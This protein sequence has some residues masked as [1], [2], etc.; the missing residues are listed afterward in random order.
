LMQQGSAD[1]KKKW[2]TRP[3]VDNWRRASSITFAA[4]G[5]GGARSGAD[6]EETAT[7][8]DFGLP[9]EE[10]LLAKIPNTSQQKEAAVKL[11]QKAYMQMAKAYFN[12][13][14]DYNRTLLTLDTLNFRYPAHAYKEEELYVR[15][16]VAIKQNQLDKAQS[17]SQDLLTRFPNSQY[18]KLL[19]PAVSESNLAGAS[20][21]KEVADYFD[22]TYKLLQMHQYTE[23]LVRIDAAKKQYNHP[24]FRKRFE[25]LEASAFAGK[26][27]YV[28]A[29]SLLRGFLKTNAS[30]TLA[31]WA[32]NVQEYVQHMRDN[33][34]P[35]WYDEAMAVA[36]AAKTPGSKTPEETAAAKPVVPTPP[37]PMPD[38]PRMYTYQADSEHYCIIVFPG[39]DSRTVGLKQSIK[40]LDSAKY[41]S[42]AHQLLIV[43]WRNGDQVF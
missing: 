1:F 33:G 32:R 10:S 43:P 21:A 12:Q 17:I 26:G 5:T 14:E 2:G 41:A 27:D 30:D 13:L 19:K 37:P 40:K 38:A 8:A 11:T 15:Y 28:T 25:V 31:V 9:T 23:V 39:L 16:Q 20:S 42:A 3:L 36:S 22:E 35:G 7:A 6:A 24:R 34:K 4:S 18:A 29:D